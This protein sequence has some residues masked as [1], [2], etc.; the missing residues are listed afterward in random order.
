MGGRVSGEGPCLSVLF[1][2]EGMLRD[3]QK[4]VE[5]EEQVWKAKVSATEEELQQ[6]QEGPKALSQGP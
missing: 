1:P 5:D 3:L 4:S 2:Q 6:V